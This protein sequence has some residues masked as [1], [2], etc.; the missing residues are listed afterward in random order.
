M[1]NNMDQLKVIKKGK[2][3]NVAN[4]KNDR[5]YVFYAPDEPSLDR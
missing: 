5:G 3:L 4:Y 1:K 2:D